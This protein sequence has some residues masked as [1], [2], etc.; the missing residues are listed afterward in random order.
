MVVFIIGIF[1]DLCKGTECVVT[2]SPQHKQL[3]M[4]SGS[5]QTSRSGCPSCFCSLLLCN[6]RYS[7][8][9]IHDMQ[10][11]VVCKQQHLSCWITSLQRCKAPCLC[12]LCYC[13]S[14]SSVFVLHLQMGRGDDA[15]KA[16]DEAQQLSRSS[17]APDVLNQASVT[18][19]HLLQVCSTT[20]NCT[21]LHPVCTCNID[22]S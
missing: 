4:L 21:S 2:C 6:L 5:C 22:L 14:A 17:A 10:A 9:T 19:A 8:G 3:W 12:M 15:V 18:Q 16:I 20:L 11:Y 1:R 13:Y 7:P